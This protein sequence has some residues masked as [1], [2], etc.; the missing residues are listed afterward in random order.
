MEVSDAAVKASY[1]I[2]NEISVA[3][4]PFSAGD[5][6]MNCLLAV[7]DIVCRE[8]CQLFAHKSLTWNSSCDRISGVTADLYDTVMTKVT[9]FVVF[10]AATDE[11]TD[12]AQHAIFIRGVIGSL[13]ATE[14]FV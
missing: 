7:T 14:E 2:A 4:K 10:S 11:G 9:S 13:A 5:L 12:I 8:K 3:S 1:L 6:V